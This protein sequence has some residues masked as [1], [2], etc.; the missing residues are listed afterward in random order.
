MELARPFLKVFRKNL[1][2]ICLV[3]YVFT[4]IWNKEVL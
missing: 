2:C 1:W 4:V 3:R